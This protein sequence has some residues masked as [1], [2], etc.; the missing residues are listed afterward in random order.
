MKLY[1]IRH[2]ETNW[3][4]ERRMQGSADIELNDY[5]RKLAY[6]TKQG[7]SKIPFDIAYTSPLWRARE[8][9]EIILEEKQVPLYEDKRLTEIDF[10]SYEGI[11]EKDLYEAHDDFMNFF[12]CPEKF[13]TKGGSETHEDVIGRAEDFMQHVILPNEN[14]YKH[15]AVFTHGGWIHAMLTSIYQ[16]GIKDFW[17]GPRQENCGVTTI[18]IENGRCR[19]IRESEI[20]YEKGDCNDKK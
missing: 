4:K 18:E 20:F 10:G 17:H 6:L 14:K 2:G 19:V 9:G 3:N 12:D 5:G 16:R 11:R 13:R 1:L 8:T 7:L 15:M